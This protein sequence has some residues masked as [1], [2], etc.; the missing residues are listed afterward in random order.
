M[1][2]PV[3]TTANS[4]DRFARG[5][6][7]GA[8]LAT[9]PFLWMVTSGTFNLLRP[10][11]FGSNFYDVQAH[12]L[13]QGHWD[14]PPS[15]MQIEGIVIGHRTYMYY[16]PTP[17]LFR[18]P[19]ALIT[20]GLD[21][22]LTAISMLVAFEVALGVLAH[23]SW[24]VRWLVRGPAPVTTAE[25]W[26]AGVWTLFA[27]AGSILLFLAG[28][29][30]VYQEAELWGAALALAT[31]DVILGFVI[32]PAG[33]KLVAAG[34]LATLAI[35]TRASIGEAPLVALGLL[36]AAHVVVWLSRRMTK[37]A[38]GRW[39]RLG[40]PRQ[41]GW[42]ALPGAS[43]RTYGGGLVAA[44]LV[45]AALYAAV[46]E[47][48]F[49]TLYS[50][51]LNH[52]IYSGQSPSRQAALAANGGSL[53]GLKFIP[54]T[55]LQYLRP[56]ALR[57]H[58]LFPFIG[59]P[60]PAKVLFHV[61]F[62]TLDFA[63]S[64][65]ATMPFFVI[66]A[67]VGLYALGRRPARSRAGG[68]AAVRT[69]TLGA[70]AGTVASISIAYVANRYLSD[71]F[72][73]LAVCS[74][75][76]VWF[77]AARWTAVRRRTIVA[78]LAVA[79][80]AGAFGIWSAVALGFVFQRAL[81]PTT[82]TETT[83]AALVSLQE[84]IDTR[85][86]DGVP[87]DVRFGT[88]LPHHAP[89]YGLFVLGRC[90]ALYLSDGRHWFGVEEGNAAG[91]FRMAVSF[92]DAAP[93]TRQ[94]LLSAGDPRN[95][96]YLAVHFL[97]EGWVALSYRSDS[98]GRWQDGQ[99]LTATAGHTYLIDAVI[100]RRVDTDE[101]SATVDGRPALELTPLFQVPAPAQ[102]VNVQPVPA[103]FAGTIVQLPVETPICS[104][105]LRR[106]GGGS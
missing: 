7:V 69:V 81:S 85:L 21:G 72:P 45:P 30:T 46:N 36:A 52:Q 98:T 89:T 78:S 16:G 6:A 5:C 86:F 58:R 92:P 64:A 3:D 40:A 34:V 2:A 33:R 15:V 73:F 54:T 71:A 63:S 27:G 104:S 82:A 32:R 93:D 10:G 75:V 18:L 31:L 53:F 12:R 67:L 43:A 95:P 19:V 14:V 51:P 4:V 41:K 96:A 49:H 13:L 84:R 105:L 39:R 50:L 90:D 61:R 101:V 25:V 68:V 9:L 76:G 38:S 57:F 48:K 55:V 35:L 88:L 1:T 97:A 42:L 65:T 22:R 11:G 94:P 56:D 66:T 77:L 102:S 59:F 74:L 23:L 62:D 80:L 70:A 24:R 37:G 99:V 106:S 103:L 17:A 60:P 100:D 28:W 8:A 29:P 20:H 26:I 91:H 87:A 83:R 79:A 44:T 47:I